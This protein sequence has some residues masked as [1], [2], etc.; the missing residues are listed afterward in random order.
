MPSELHVLVRMVGTT[1]WGTAQ[2]ATRPSWER[3]LTLLA[4]ALRTPTPSVLP[5]L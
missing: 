2:T 5:A 1:A 4:D 3:Y